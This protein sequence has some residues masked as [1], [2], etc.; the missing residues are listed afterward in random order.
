MC[1]PQ[2]VTTKMTRDTP[3]VESVCTRKSARPP[4]EWWSPGSCGAALGCDQRSFLRLLTKKE[5][6][7]KKRNWKRTISFKMTTTNLQKPNNSNPLTSSSNSDAKITGIANT[8]GLSNRIDLLDCDHGRILCIADL[9]GAI[10]QINILAKQ[11]NA[12]A[13]IHSGDFGFYGQS[14][15][16]TSSCEPSFLAADLALLLLL[17]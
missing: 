14:T 16:S 7:K 13:V 4:G 6:R 15:S 8:S 10:S 3:N 2:W 11:F 9:R 1:N 12:V 5:K 17:V